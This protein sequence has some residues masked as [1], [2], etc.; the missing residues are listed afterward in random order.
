ME[1]SENNITKRSTS[2]LFIAI[3]LSGAMIAL[4]I[5]FTRG[6]P[7]TPSE[8]DPLAQVK[9]GVSDT[10]IDPA[11]TTFKNVRKVAIGYCGEVNAKNRMGGYVGYQ[12]FHAFDKADKSG[13]WVV[14]YE[15]PLI[16]VMCE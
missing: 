11:S 2:G 9:A 14:I 4:A 16:Q 10:M 6:A 15:E 5:L 13:K 7:T 1:Q 8:P 12:K 3:I